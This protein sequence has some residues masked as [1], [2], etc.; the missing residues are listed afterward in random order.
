MSFGADGSM[1]LSIAAFRDDT[2]A[3]LYR[4]SLG[5]SILQGRQRCRPLWTEGPIC[6]GAYRCPIN[7]GFSASC[8]PTNA[9]AQGN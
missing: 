4:L 7:M 3:A 6:S 2:V 8:R 1:G 9:A 5:R